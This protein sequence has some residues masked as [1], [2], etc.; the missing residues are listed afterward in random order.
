MLDIE[1]LVDSLPFNISTPTLSDENSAVNLV[2]HIFYM[3]G[4]FFLAVFR[5]LTSPFGFR[6]F[7]YDYVSLLVYHILEFVELM[8][9]QWLP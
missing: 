9:R 3:V 1:F 7:N 4:H 5:I 8:I 6:L 2:E